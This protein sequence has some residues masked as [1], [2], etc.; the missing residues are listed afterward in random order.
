MEE[1]I[2]GV[3]KTK[4]ELAQEELDDIAAGVAEQQ[5]QEEEGGFVDETEEGMST[6]EPNSWV[7]VINQNGNPWLPFNEEAAKK[8][9]GAYQAYTDSRI[10]LRE[11]L[12]PEESADLNALESRLGVKLPQGLINRL[13]KL[14]DSHEGQ[15]IR[16]TVVPQ[17]FVEVNKTK[18]EDEPEIKDRIFKE[19]VI[20][21]FKSE[22]K[23]R[24]KKA[25]KEEF[26]NAVNEIKNTHNRFNLEHVIDTYPVIAEQFGFAK[27][28]LGFVIKYLPS[29]ESNL[30]MDYSNTKRGPLPITE[31]ELS[32]IHI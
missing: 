7:E 10:A 27:N 26:V 6:R 4:A 24:R 31:E 8:V 2:E 22:G 29:P 5:V 19:E 9:E 12:Q 15:A 30:I 13:I 16:Y 17:H 11:R 28:K 23:D 1:D 20:R 14:I 18:K 21:Q 25:I 3:A 32:L